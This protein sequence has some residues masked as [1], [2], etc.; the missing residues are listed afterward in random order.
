MKKLLF[1]LLLPTLSFAD[2]LGSL[3]SGAD[4]FLTTQ[5]ASYFPVKIGSGTV[6]PFDVSSTSASVTGAGGLGIF[7]FAPTGTYEFQASTSTSFAHVAISTSGHFITGGSTPTISSCGV[8]PSG[9]VLGDDNVGVITIGGGVV[10]AC[11]ITFAS[12]WGVVPVC[13]F[14]P[15]S[16]IV[17][18]GP[19]TKSASAVTF[20]LSANLG[21]G[22]VEYHCR[23]SGS[24]CR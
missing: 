18:A 24:S 6:G 3:R 5:T 23:C 21:G 7:D 19:T 11:T 1:L 9:S 2:R 15:D 10:T 12:T 13:V 22:V 14:D 8:T 17:F 16:A 4:V 20:T